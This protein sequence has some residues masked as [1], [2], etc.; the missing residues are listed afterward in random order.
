[1]VGDVDVLDTTLIYSGVMVLQMTNMI[2]EVKVLFSYEMAP[3]PTSIFD[4]FGKICVDKSKGKLRKLLAK[5]V[6]A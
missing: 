4:E 3:F 5:E 2:I 6:S 1:M